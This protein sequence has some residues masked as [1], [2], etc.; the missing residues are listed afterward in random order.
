MTAEAIDNAFTLDMAMGGSTN[1]IL[2]TLAIAREAQVDYPLSRVNEIA[3]RTPHICKLS[4]ASNYRMADLDR[5][6]GVSAILRELSKK[7]GALH[8][9]QMTVTMKTLGEN[10]SEAKVN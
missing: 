1:T 8:L 7:D 3:E 9:D 6:G 5:A 4:P 10:I 2:H